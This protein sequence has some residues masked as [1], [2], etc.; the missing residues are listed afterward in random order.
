MSNSTS[1]TQTPHTK[2]S[3]SYHKLITGMI[4]AGLSYQEAQIQASR[5]MAE[6][7]LSS[8]S[9]SAFDEVLFF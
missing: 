4:T 8:N 5:I 9:E 7:N 1:K 3:I 6:H 2:R